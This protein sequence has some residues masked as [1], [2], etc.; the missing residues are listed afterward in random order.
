MTRLQLKNG[1][2]GLETPHVVAY[3]LGMGSASRPGGRFRRRA[4]APENSPAMNGEAM[5][6]ALARS[7]GWRLLSGE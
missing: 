3:G 6:E 4:A 1:G 2:G 7:F 5:V